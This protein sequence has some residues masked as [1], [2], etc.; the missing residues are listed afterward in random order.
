MRNP[1][2]ALADRKMQKKSAGTFNFFSFVL[3]E[4]ES[5]CGYLSS[6]IIIGILGFV[7]KLKELS[8]HCKPYM[9]VSL[10]VG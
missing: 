1:F 4:C 5:G 6:I 9:A 8:L 2:S 3:P 10:A 7:S